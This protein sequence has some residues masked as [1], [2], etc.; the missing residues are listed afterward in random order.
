MTKIMANLPI[1]IDQGS[2]TLMNIAKRRA[3]QEIRANTQGTGAL[4]EGIMIKKTKL[5]KGTTVWK[6]GINDAVA[7]YAGAVHDGFASHWVHRDM[8]GA[9]LAKHPD[10]KLTGGKWLEVGYPKTGTRSDGSAKQSAPWLTQGGVKYFDKAYA[11]I[12][13]LTTQEYK[14]RIQQAL[15]R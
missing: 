5:D 7:R 10:V 11:E 8:L 3:K 12:L 6:L 1:Q 14:K 4:A 9:W 2:E 13:N 15:K